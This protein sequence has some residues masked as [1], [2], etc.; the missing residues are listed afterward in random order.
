M[1]FLGVVSAKLTVRVSFKTRK[2][3]YYPESTLA[4]AP[5]V[6]YSHYTHLRRH[7]YANWKEIEK[8]KIVQVCMTVAVAGAW[9][10]V[11][12]QCVGVCVYMSVCR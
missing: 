9:P 10:I 11:N 12:G 4:T 2:T 7:D 1:A 5:L 3:K 6:F 8:E